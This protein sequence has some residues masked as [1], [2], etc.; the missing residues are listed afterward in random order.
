MPVKAQLVMDA[1]RDTGYLLYLI[2]WT[3]LIVGISLLTG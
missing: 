1:F 3:E 2:Q